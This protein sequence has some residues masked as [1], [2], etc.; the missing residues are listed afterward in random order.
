LRW[1]PGKVTHRGA[2]GNSGSRAADSPGG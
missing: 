2:A 1:D